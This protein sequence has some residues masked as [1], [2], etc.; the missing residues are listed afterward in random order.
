[1]SPKLFLPAAD[2]EVL[3]DV[4]REAG[5]SCSVSADLPREPRVE[6]RPLFPTDGGARETDGVDAPDRV[7][8]VDCCRRTAGPEP[9]TGAFVKVGVDWDSDAKTEARGLS[10]VSR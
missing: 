6:E 9:P 2:V 1:M 10:R 5:G 7:D 8:K 3:P 4:V